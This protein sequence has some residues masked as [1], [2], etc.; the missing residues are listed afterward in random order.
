MRES[1]E[2]KEKVAVIG[3]LKGKVDAILEGGRESGCHLGGKGGRVDAIS[4]GR[5]GRVDAI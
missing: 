2:K 5:E 1:F 3:R 4:E